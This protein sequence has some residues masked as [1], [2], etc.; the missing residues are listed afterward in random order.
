MKVGG[1]GA[2]IRAST[3]FR[4]KLMKQNEG[5]IEERTVNGKSYIVH[6]L[7]FFEERGGG[8]E[9]DIFSSWWGR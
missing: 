6:A 1:C 8:G 4:C 2:D 3:S 9:G 5:G 7:R